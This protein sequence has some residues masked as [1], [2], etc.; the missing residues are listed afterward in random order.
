MLTYW[1]KK[2][3]KSFLNRLISI[4]WYFLCRYFNGRRI[5]ENATLYEFLDNKLRLKKVDRHSLGSYFC[6][7]ENEVGA[8]NSSEA[9]VNVLC[10]YHPEMLPFEVALHHYSSLMVVHRSSNRLCGFDDTDNGQRD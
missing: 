6:S 4:F 5:G 1:L 8:S 3:L 2:V 10:K 9:V 7:L